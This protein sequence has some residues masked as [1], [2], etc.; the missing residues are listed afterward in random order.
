M[1]KQQKEYGN[2]SLDQFQK[3]VRKLPEIRSQSIFSRVGCADAG[4]EI[5][6]AII[7]TENGMK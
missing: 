5:T 2:L 3:I 6:L 4:K 7:F 1:E